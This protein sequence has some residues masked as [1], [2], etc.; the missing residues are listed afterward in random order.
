MI[1]ALFGN[2]IGSRIKEGEYKGAHSC[3]A[4]GK[5]EYWKYSG[6]QPV[7][8]PEEIAKAQ[9]LKN[10]DEV[11]PRHTN[12][13]P[14]KLGEMTNEERRGCI[15]RACVRLQVEFND[16]RIQRAMGIALAELTD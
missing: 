2:T 12:G 15:E 9:K 8:T 16:P 3:P 6:T 1:V 11:W 7:H 4:C 13:V 5:E 14:K 10:P